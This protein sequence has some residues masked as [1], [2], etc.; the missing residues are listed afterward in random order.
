V[1]VVDGQS[2]LNRWQVEGMHRRY[3]RQGSK[4]NRLR[5]CSAAIILQ[6]PQL[7]IVLERS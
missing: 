3:R 7:G 6:W 1:V 4:G 5:E 2:A